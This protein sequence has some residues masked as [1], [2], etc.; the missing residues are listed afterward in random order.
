MNTRADR[1]N[2][3][4]RTTS[5]ATPEAKPTIAPFSGPATNPATT[6]TRTMTSGRA[7]SNEKR[8]NSETWN[9]RAVRTTTVTFQGFT[10]VGP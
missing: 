3:V 10:V 9:N 5:N 8:E 4:D 2:G 6:A 7:P 1:P